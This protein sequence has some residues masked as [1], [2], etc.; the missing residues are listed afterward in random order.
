MDTVL[1]L[2]QIVA[3]LCLAALSIYLIV[4]LVQLRSVLMNLE[5]DF[6][7]FAS[8]AIPVLENIEAITAKFKNV[9]ASIDEEIGAIKQSMNSM[10]QIAENVLE[11]ERKVQERIEIP[12]METVATVAAVFKGV[13]TFLDRLRS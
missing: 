9:A 8:Q 7:E 12:V 6:K 1:I 3:L 10:R 13:R 4:V 11:F 5:K 2:A